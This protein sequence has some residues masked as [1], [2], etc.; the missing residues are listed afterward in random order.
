MVDTTPITR[1]IAKL[2][3]NGTISEQVLLAA[4]VRLFPDL[5]SRELSQVLQC[6]QAAAE[7]KAAAKH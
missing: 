7:K 1:E 5:D 6:A 3:S 2:I 4:A